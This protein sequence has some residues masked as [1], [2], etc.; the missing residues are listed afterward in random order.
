MTEIFVFLITLV[1]CATV[2]VWKALDL[3]I[4]GVN[5][6]D[7]F[8]KKDNKTKKK[9]EISN[10]TWKYRTSEQIKKKNEHEV[11]GK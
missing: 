6:F 7:V 2:I 3:L 10:N 1:I 9:T 11:S 8:R 4:D 5:V